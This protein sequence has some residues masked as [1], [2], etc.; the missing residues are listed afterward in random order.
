MANRTWREP[1]S[2]NI[3][4][5]NVEGSFAPN[6][7]S[8]I[9]SASNSGSGWSVVRT[10]TGL[11]TITLEDSYVGVYAASAHLQLAA[12]DDK[13]AQLGAIDVTSAKTVQIR[14]WDVSAAAV[15]DLADNAN[16][17]IH[18]SLQLKNT[19]VRY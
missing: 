10:S 17:R 15:A 11:F 12:G 18:F 3:G 5:V 9:D 8:A 16:N 2:K 4:V 1:E 13:I 6:G 7:S 19:T 14:I